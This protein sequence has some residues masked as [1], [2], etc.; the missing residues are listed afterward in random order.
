MLHDSKG[1]RDLRKGVRG[2]QQVFAFMRGANDGAQPGLSLAHGWIADGGREYTGVEQFAG[3]FK[4]FGGVAYVNRNDR[5]FADF[6]F[7]AAFLQFA[8]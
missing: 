6:E 5:G 2:F 3:K 8:L 1:L 7:K 4:G